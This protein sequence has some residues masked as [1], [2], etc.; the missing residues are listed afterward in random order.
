MKL[1]WV[2]ALF[3]SATAVAQ[4]QITPVVN[5]NSRYLVERIEVAGEGEFRLSRSV[6]EDIERLIGGNFDEQ[7]LEELGSRI[8]KEIHAKTVTY[9]VMRGR[10]PEHVAVE[11]EVVRRSVDF[12]V[13]VPK[14]LFHSKQGWTGVVEAGAAMGATTASVRLLSDADELAERNAGIAARFE[15][16]RVGSDRVRVAFDVE[17]YHEQWS[18]ALARMPQDDPSLLALYRTRQNFQPTVT[19][20]LARPLTFTT[21]LSFQRFQT[22]FPA[23]RYESA[24]AVVN[25]LRYHWVGEDSDAKQTLD[26]GYNL[27]AATRFLSGD[28]AYVRHFWTFGYS[29]THGNQT[30]LVNL[31]GGIIG[32]NAPLYERFVLGNSTTLRGWNKYDIAPL[33]GTRMAHNSVEYRYR[34]LQIFFDTGSV[35]TRGKQAVARNAV[36]AGLRKDGFSLAVAFPVK[37]GRADPIF[38]AGMNF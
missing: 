4:S 19:V 38:V 3:S 26:A 18:K 6:H 12:N 30:I 17:S 11:F 35:W 22:Q 13:G 7:L 34:Y 25:T 9:R 31:I 2:V 29:N 23:A 27:R 10:Q 5:I 33:G 8:K 24:H 37:E 32:G 36:G 20:V 28:F 16:K 21:G 14:F 15:Q 1:L